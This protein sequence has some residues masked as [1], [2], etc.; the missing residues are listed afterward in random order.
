MSN[1][2]AEA[3]AETGKQTPE[4][5]SDLVD[6]SPYKTTDAKVDFRQDPTRLQIEDQSFDM[7]ICTAD[8]SPTRGLHEYQFRTG[9]YRIRAKRDDQSEYGTSWRIEADVVGENNDE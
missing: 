7:G 8:D 3:K 4:T 9:S 2:E 1:G 6:K 5:L